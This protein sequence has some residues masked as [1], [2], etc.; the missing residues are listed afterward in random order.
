MENILKWIN[1]KLAAPLYKVTQ[2]RWI[3]A[4]LEGFQRNMTIIIIGAMF[5]IISRIV[6]MITENPDNIWMVMYNYT[7]GLLAL[8]LAF[9]IAAKLAKHYEVNEN[10]TGLVAICAFVILQRPAIIDGSFQIDFQRLGAVGLFVAIVAGVFVGELMGLFLKRKW[11]FKTDAL[12]DFVSEWFAPIIPAALAIVISWI[13]ADVLNLDLFMIIAKAITPLMSTSDAY[14]A[15]LGTCFFLTMLFAIGINGAVTFGILIPLWV[16]AIG[17][18]ASLMQQGLD[19]TH[20]NTMQTLNGWVVLGGTGATLT[21]NLMLLFAKSKSLK[22]LGKASIVPGLLNINEPLIYGLPIA[23]NPLLAIPFIIN[24]GLINPTLVYLSMHS[25]WVAK[26]FVPMFMPW[27]PVGI[28]G[29]IFNQDF[30]GV[31]L[32]LIE[33]VINALI[34]YPFFKSYDGLMIKKETVEAKQETIEA[35]PE[36]V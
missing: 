2:N 3:S 4:I 1:Q 31:L 27:L 20:I 28:N 34:W 22:A 13:V 18:N 7:F 17:E 16:A 8:F 19:P 6:T 36:M 10:T 14:L 12:P 24:G 30:N 33:L 29:F 26:P 35:I 21:L 25:G 9:N 11:T 23:F 5:Q 32:V 15:F